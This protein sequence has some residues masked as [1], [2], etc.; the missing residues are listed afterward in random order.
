[1]QSVTVA[2]FYWRPEAA[3]L[4]LR[5]QVAILRAAP[6]LFSMNVSGAVEEKHAFFELESCA[7]H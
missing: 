2:G 3:L 5:P 6:M 7:T 1:M 4:L